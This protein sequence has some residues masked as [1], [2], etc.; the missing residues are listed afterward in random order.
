MATPRIVR[1]GRDVYREAK[2]DD[3]TGMAA[4]LAF[5]FFM[6]LFP[7]VLV[8]V[9]LGAFISRAAGVD[10]PSDYVLDAVGDSLPS[11]AASVI[12]TQVDEVIAGA[13][14]GLLSIGIATAIW[15]AS[16]GAG[17]LMKATNRVYDLPETR[18]F[19]VQ[20]GIAIGLTTLGGLGLLVAV[21]AMVLTQAFAGS[22]ASAIGLGR[23]FGWVVQ[24]L[25]FPLIVL[26]VAAAAETVYWLAPNRWSRPD[27]ANWGSAFF[28]V[29]W[30]A[31]T[32]GF[33]IYVANFSSYN[34]TYGAIAGVVILLFW[35]YVSSLLI[36]LGAEINSV[37]ET[38][39][40]QQT[41]VTALEI[42][43][44]ETRPPRASGR[45]SLELAVFAGAA[46]ALFGWLRRKPADQL[47]H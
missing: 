23:E 17:A 19:Y 46:L 22:I 18:K 3:L 9:T 5:R 14:V 30:S 20:T 21:S 8:L 12:R 32:V 41:V 47:P 25:R 26:F 43:E 16:G 39:K 33:A 27:L 31:F 2:G 28:A 15:S 45:P 10:D 4:E 38:A 35:F 44:A 24:L 29:G 40:A 1:F 11:D 6:A 13:S 37:L 36:L 7:F 42:A 34:A